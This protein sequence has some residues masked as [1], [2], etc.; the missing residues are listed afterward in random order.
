MVFTF[1]QYFVDDIIFNAEVI[2]FINISFYDTGFSGKVTPIM[3]GESP[4][5]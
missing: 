5:K 2:F 4:S 1:V 3:L